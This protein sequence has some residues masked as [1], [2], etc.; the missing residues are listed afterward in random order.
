MFPE[1]NRPRGSISPKKTEAE[2]K[3][4]DR[5]LQEVR[6]IMDAQQKELR[7]RLRHIDEEYPP[8]K[9]EVLD[10]SFDDI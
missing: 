9:G 5:E 7:R 8:A 10:Q 3:A 6:E 4:E 1:R 2:D